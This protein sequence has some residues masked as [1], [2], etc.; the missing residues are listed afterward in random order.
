[1]DLVFEDEDGLVVVDYKTDRIAGPDTVHA[2]ATY[3]RPQIAAYATALERSCGQQVSRCVLLLLG[4]DRLTQY[5]L[6]GKELAAARAEALE[7]AM[8]LTG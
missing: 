2:T 7:L 3:Y 1:V 4:N 5:V 6:E 8:A